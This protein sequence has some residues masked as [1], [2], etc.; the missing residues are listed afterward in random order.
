MSNPITSCCSEYSL[1]VFR[2]RFYDYYKIY[3]G[4]VFIILIYN[5]VSSRQPTPDFYSQMKMECCS[6]EHILRSLIYSY[7]HFRSPKSA[8]LALRLTIFGHSK[9]WLSTCRFQPIAY[10]IAKGNWV[11]K[12]AATDRYETTARAYNAKMGLVTAEMYRIGLLNYLSL[13]ILFNHLKN[14]S[15]PVTGCGGL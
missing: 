6:V 10:N 3:T 2:F 14:K 7:R 1:F 9:P 13:T 15:I 12:T 4:F 8:K 11:G 5:V